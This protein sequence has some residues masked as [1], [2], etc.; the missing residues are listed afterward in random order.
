MATKRKYFIEMF[1]IDWLVS[2]LVGF[3]GGRDLSVSIISGE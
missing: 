2:W 1:D 3:K